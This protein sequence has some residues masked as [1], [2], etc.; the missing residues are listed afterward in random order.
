MS[1]GTEW[2]PNRGVTLAL[3]NPVPV[4]QQLLEALGLGDVEV[5]VAALAPLGAH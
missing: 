2:L 3:P 5:A 1:D 4:L